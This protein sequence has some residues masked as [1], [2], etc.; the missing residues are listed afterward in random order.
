MRGK[1]I[2]KDETWTT[3]NEISYLDG[4]GTWGKVALSKKEMLENYIKA[5][6]RRDDWGEIDVFKVMEYAAGML[7]EERV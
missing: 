2:R 6:C 3:E 5:A 1:R 7:D 4:I